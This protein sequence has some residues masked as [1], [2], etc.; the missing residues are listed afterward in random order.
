MSN[1]I[2]VPEKVSLSEAGIGESIIEQ[3]IAENPAILGLGELDLKGRQRYQPKAGR[4]DL[5]LQDPDSERRYEIEIQL[6]ETDE[7]HI[8]RTIEYWDIE[9]KRYP[10]YEHCAVIIAEKITSRFHN[11]I[12]L[13]NRSIPLIA[14]QVNAYKFENNVGLV[15]TV[16][17]DEFSN[18]VSDESTGDV[19]DRNYWIN[20]GTEKTVGIADKLLEIVN[21]FAVGYKLKYNQFYMGLERDNHVNNFVYFSPKKSGTNIYIQLPFSEETQN[22]MEQNGLHFVNYRGNRYFLRIGSINEVNEKINI[23]KEIFNQA[24]EYSK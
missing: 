11:V 19:V 10:Q 21:E 23:L 15:F 16:V 2:F 3:K 24:Y 1:P 4:L 7:S 13:F 18:D 20:R 12:G 6:G 17:L 9:R 22:K 5:L 14:V 8:I